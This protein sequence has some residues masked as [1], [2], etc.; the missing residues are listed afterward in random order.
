VLKKRILIVDDQIGIR[1]LLSVLFYEAGFEIFEASSGLE[2]VNMV[3]KHQLDL[4]V[5]DLRMPGMNG[6][7]AFTRMKKMDS[8]IKVVLMS[9]F[10]EDETANYALKKGA[11]GFFH[12][13]FDLQMLK[14]FVLSLAGEKDQQVYLA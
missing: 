7:E 10:A 6:M 12:K 2:A 11:A 3:D 4:V 5:M 9:A 8:K 1:S 13:P 14:D